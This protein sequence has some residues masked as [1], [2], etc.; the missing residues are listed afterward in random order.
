MYLI[1][2]ISCDIINKKFKIILQKRSQRFSGTFHISC[3]GGELSHVDKKSKKYG[4]IKDNAGY[5]EVQKIKKSG[6][7]GDGF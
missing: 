7:F 1:I 4:A 2:D 5:G 3:V 6:L